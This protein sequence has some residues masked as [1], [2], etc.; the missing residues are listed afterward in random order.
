MPRNDYQDTKQYIPNLLNDPTI[1]DEQKA[2]LQRVQHQCIHEGRVVDARFVALVNIK[3]S[4]PIFGFDCLDT[5]TD[6]ICP[7]FVH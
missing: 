2:Y 1:P 4:F 3:V 5:V 6:Q 7:C